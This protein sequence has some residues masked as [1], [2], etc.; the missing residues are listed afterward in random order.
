MATPGPIRTALGRNCCGS[1]SES[2]LT[3]GAVIFCR[4]LPGRA[5]GRGPAPAAFWVPTA[6]Y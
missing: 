5:D 1:L 4:A 3:S 6:L 2:R